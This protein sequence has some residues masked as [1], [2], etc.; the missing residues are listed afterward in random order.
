MNHPDND[1]TKFSDSAPARNNRGKR[2][3]KGSGEVTGSGAGAG[4]SGGPED[5]D[6][7]PVGGGGSFPPARPGDGGDGADA[8]SH[9]SR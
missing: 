3:G 9:G 7:D 5:Y 8:P 6:S 1:E 2:P 4:G